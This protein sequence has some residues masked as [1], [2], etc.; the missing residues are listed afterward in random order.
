MSSARS[1]RGGAESCNPVPAIDRRDD[2]KD[3]GRLRRGDHEDGCVALTRGRD[4]IAAVPDDPRHRAVG[5]AEDGEDPRP[6]QRFRVVGHYAEIDDMRD[7]SRVCGETAITRQ[8]APGS[9]RQNLVDAGCR[10]NHL[11]P[12]F[13]LRSRTAVNLIAYCLRH[14]PETTLQ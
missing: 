4:P 10:Q 6:E 12:S 2:H 5:G 14:S 1:G 9:R 8:S 13:Q 7:L 3:P 11:R